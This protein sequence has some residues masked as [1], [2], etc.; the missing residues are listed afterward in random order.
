VYQEVLLGGLLEVFGK[1][2]FVL[3]EDLGVLGDHDAAEVGLQ[4]EVGRVRE[5]LLG[6]R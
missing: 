1:G 4:I 3:F 5:E 6:L 2:C